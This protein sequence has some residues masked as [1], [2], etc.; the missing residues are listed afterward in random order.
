MFSLK[1]RTLLRPS[2]FEL[3]DF[4]Y[5][6]NSFPSADIWRPF[7]ES[8]RCF[9]MMAS[10]STMTE[11]TFGGF[12]LESLKNAMKKQLEYT[13]L[14]MWWLLIPPWLNPEIS[15]MQWWK[16]RI[17]MF[18]KIIFFNSNLVL[19]TLLFEIPNIEWHNLPSIY[20]N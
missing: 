1:L 18:D 11:E 7:T 15:K 6:A 17:I 3:R 4:S 12:S 14:A 2:N 16:H 8:C 10:N 5:K 13:C 19:E 9:T 20:T